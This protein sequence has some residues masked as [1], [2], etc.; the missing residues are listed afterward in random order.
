VSLFEIITMIAG[1]FG[2]VL[3]F[4]LF[5]QVDEQQKAQDRLDDDIHKLEVRMIEN[6]VSRAT[7][8]DMFTTR[9]NRL[10]RKVDRLLAARGVE[11]ESWED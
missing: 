6:Y 2:S 5:Q 7:L 8:N 1:F 3:M 10:E 11:G 4:R 9:I